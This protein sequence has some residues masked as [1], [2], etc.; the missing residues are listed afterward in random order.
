MRTTV[1]ASVGDRVQIRDWSGF[2]YEMGIVFGCHLRRYQA[3]R[4]LDIQGE[5]GALIPESHDTHEKFFQWHLSDVTGESNASVMFHRLSYCI[6]LPYFVDP[7]T[8]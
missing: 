6:V 3:Y 7:A 8:A 2:S 4:V 1:K 5:M